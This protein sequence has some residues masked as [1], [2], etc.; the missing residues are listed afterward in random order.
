VKALEHLYTLGALNDEGKLSDPLGV[1]MARFPLEPLYA[2]A[3]LVS[4]DMGCS[5]EMLAAV[6]MLS[7]ESIF[8]APRDKLQEVIMFFSSDKIDL[9]N[10]LLDLCSLNIFRSD[11][12][13]ILS[14]EWP[15]LLLSCKC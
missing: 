4:S 12:S 14:C 6:S 11:S 9:F 8:F 5:E 2:K 7:V 13:S 3:M 15:C 10:C 1:R